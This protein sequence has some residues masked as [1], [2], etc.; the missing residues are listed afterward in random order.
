MSE[1]GSPDPTADDA[2]SDPAPPPVPEEFVLLYDEDELARIEQQ[3]VVVAAQRILEEVEE[4]GADVTLEDGDDGPSLGTTAGGLVRRYGMIGAMGAQSM[5][6]LAE[7]IEP[8]KA[9]R[10]VIEFAPD[11]VPEDE[12]PV[13][14]HFV[15]GDPQASRLVI[16]PWLLGRRRRSREP[17]TSS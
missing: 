6:G 14:F 3:R 7:V 8:E 15:P 5:L 1:S 10:T 9:K 17:S 11:R 13:T 16:R 4:V 2:P 12:Q